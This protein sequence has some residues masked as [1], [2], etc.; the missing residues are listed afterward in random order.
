[1]FCS[2][3][4]VR[5]GP[6]NFLRLMSAILCERRIMF[7]AEDLTTLSECVHAATTVLYPFAWQH[8]LVPMLP[9]DM[10]EYVSAPMPFIIG[11]SAPPRLRPAFGPWYGRR[12]A[13]GRRVST[14][15][16]PVDFV[17][18]SRGRAHRSPR[19]EGEPIPACDLVV[20][21]SRVWIVWL[22]RS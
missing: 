13:V 5:L 3:D 19:A 2:S 18:F 21:W 8:V 7:V 4:K 6:R 20:G 9:T 16:P 11:V 1:M 22:G 14:G 17:S 15:F 10:L 12:T